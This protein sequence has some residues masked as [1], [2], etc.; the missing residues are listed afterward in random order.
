M[1]KELASDRER[2]L[3]DEV[4][5]LSIVIS[6]FMG[7]IKKKRLKEED[8]HEN[9]MNNTDTDKIMKIM[10]MRWSKKKSRQRGTLV[11]IR[12]QN[13]TIIVLPGLG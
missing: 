11:K 12:Q 4:F 6:N 9:V 3:L 2:V 5:Q 7:Q 13:G 1:E 10:E 8:H